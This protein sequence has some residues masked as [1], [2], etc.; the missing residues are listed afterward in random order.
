MK[1]PSERGEIPLSTFRNSAKIRLAQELKHRHDAT[2]AEQ[3]AKITALE[4]E[5]NLQT[6]D[7]AAVRIV[8]LNK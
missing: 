2:I 6:K 1:N 5:A 8:A 4:A 7:G 3:Q